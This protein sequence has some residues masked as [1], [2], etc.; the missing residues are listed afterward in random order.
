MNCTSGSMSS[1]NRTGLCMISLP[2]FPSRS[3]ES[4]WCLNPTA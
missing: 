1:A 4:A 3:V 2:S